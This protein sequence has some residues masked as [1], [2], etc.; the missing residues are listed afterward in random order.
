MWYLVLTYEGYKNRGAI[1]LIFYHTILNHH[2]NLGVTSLAEKE[3]PQELQR[4]SRYTTAV[5]D[6]T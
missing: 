2:G 3:Q 6:V 5:L 1:F 4:M